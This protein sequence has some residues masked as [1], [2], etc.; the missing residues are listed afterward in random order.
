MSLSVEIE[1]LYATDTKGLDR[2]RAL[3][4]FNE[5]KFF[6]NRGDIRA[7]ERTSDG[8]KVNL[9]VKQGLLLGFRIGALTDASINRQFRFFDKNTYPLKAVTVEDNVRL[10]P[11]GS[12]VRDGV[13]LAPGVVCMPPMYVNTGAYIDRETMIDSHVLIGS[14]AQI[15]KRVHI[16]A[17][18]QIGGVLEPVGDFPV[19]L[20]DDVFVG[21][22]CGIYDGTIVQEGA[23]IGA[24]TVLTGSSAVY[25]VVREQIYRKEAQHSLMIPPRAV[26]V[27]G[28]RPVGNTWA[29]SHHLAVATPIV[30]KYRDEHTDAAATL[31]GMLR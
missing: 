7:A 5:F 8:W 4:V 19:I 17:G 11:G 12:A 14:C 25:D 20:E 24:G 10:V 21:G 29:A 31:E 9:W 16:G 23:V 2:G 18:S 1:H 30:I 26:V 28:A 6:L 3:Q 22:N 15:G 13:Y 27:P